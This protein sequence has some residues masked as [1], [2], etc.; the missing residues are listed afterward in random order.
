M[1]ALPNAVD[2]TVSFVENGP[3]VPANPLADNGNG[4]DDFGAGTSETDAIVDVTITTAPDPA[5]QGTLAY[6]PDG[7]GAP[8][9][10]TDGTGLSVAEAATLTFTP[11]AGFRGDVPV[12]YELRDVNN[13]LS[14]ATMT[15]TGTPIPDARDDLVT[16][17]QRAPATLVN[18]FDDNGSGADDF[19]AGSDGADDVTIMTAPP[20]TQGVLQYTPD[21]GGT[22]VTVTDGTTLSEAEARTLTFTPDPAFVGDVTVPYTLTD[23]NDASDTATLTITVERDTDAD[24]IVD[25]VDIDDDN[26][27]ILDTAERVDNAVAGT[28]LDS[29][30]VFNSVA[31][32]RTLTAPAVTSLDSGFSPNDTAQVI[33]PVSWLNATAATSSAAT[34]ELVVDGTTYATITTPDDAGTQATVTYAGGASGNLATLPEGSLAGPFADWTINLPAG[35]ASTRPT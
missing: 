28:P 35:V 7:G 33:V 25:R 20:A 26:D 6:T 8:V 5:T 16:L 15:L 18:L 34:L 13:A 22:P 4:R 9:T 27:G 3:A 29:T 17:A 32:A 11:A 14:T 1:T 23:Q 31:G 24:G 10:V 21:G 12:P 2:D 19:G 30:E